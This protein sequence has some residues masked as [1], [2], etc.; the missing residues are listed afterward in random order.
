MMTLAGRR[1]SW[2]LA[3]I[4]GGT[5]V[6]AAYGLALAGIDARGA[7]FGA[8]AGLLLTG[9]LVEGW[10]GGRTFALERWAP[11]APDAI[12]GHAGRW[13]GRAPWV[14]A[15]SDPREL[16][17]WRRT[18]PVRGVV[19]VLLIFG[20]LP[21]ILYYFWARGTQTVTIGVAPAPGGAELKIIVRPQ[22]SD[23]RNQVV[24]VFNSLHE[25]V[26]GQQLGP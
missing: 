4:A 3:T 18:E 14:L 20:V 22:R 10:Q 11:L 23:G 7:L 21:G 8:V 12:R 25:L 17:H 5:L 15:K 1:V 24:D 13:F 26:S 9:A 16:I 6:G 19:L 2:P